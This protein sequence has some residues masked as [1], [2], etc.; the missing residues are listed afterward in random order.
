MYQRQIIIDAGMSDRFEFA[1]TQ[2]ASIRE[3][4]YANNK[5]EN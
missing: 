5:K 4:Y 3:R 2:N 1:L